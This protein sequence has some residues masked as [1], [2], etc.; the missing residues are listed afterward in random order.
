MNDQPTIPVYVITDGDEGVQINQGIRLS[1]V[2]AGVKVDGFDKI[3][4]ILKDLLGKNIYLAA[5]QENEW[6][7]Q[8]FDLDNYEQADATFQQQAESL[9]DRV[10][11]SY[12]GFLP[13]ADPKDLVHDIK[14]HMVRP[15]GLHIANKICF[16]LAGGEQTYNLGQ[17]QISAE[18]ISKAPRKLAEKFIKLQ[19]EFYEK[20]AGRKLE[21][22]IEDTGILDQRLV[23]KNR[24]VLEELG[25]IA[26]E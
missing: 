10:G 9:A 15:R 4:E 8:A 22:L 5:T 12:A 21:Y 7:K 1:V 14:G 20:M 23:E 16:T 26:K 25:Y 17:Y 13:F 19:V 6:I 18:W 2:G 24:K 3:V 11:L